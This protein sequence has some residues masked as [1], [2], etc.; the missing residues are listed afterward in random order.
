MPRPMPRPAPRDEADPTLESAA[1]ASHPES[2]G[3]CA[4]LAGLPDRP[5]VDGLLGPRHGVADEPR[6]DAAVLDP[7]RPVVERQDERARS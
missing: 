2:F 5:V 1:V 7:G 3:A 6:E 4:H